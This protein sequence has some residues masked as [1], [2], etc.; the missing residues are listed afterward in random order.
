[1]REPPSAVAATSGLPELVRAAQAGD[2]A[3]FAEIHRRFV[4]VVH[5]IALA[6]VARGDADDVAQDVFLRVHRTLATLRDAD[7][8]PAWICALARNVAADAARAARRRPRADALDDDVPAPAAAGSDE[9]LRARVLRALATLPETYRE[10][11]LL[12][13]AEGLTGPEIAERTGLAPGSV[14]VNLC[15]GMALLRPLLS[16]EGGR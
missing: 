5:G 15:R 16:D 2:A 10:T 13:L 12:R 7:A 6:R 14:R 9:E 3:A 11:L 4:P 8:F 1:M